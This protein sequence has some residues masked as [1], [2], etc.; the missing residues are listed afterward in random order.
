M[1]LPFEYVFTIFIPQ[2]SDVFLHRRI[3]ETQIF[4][5]A[6]EEQVSSDIDSVSVG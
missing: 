3:R 6:L 2:F 4:L 5:P 1:P